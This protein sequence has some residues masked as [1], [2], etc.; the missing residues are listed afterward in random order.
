[1][2]ITWIGGGERVMDVIAKQFS[3]KIYTLAKMGRGERFKNIEEISNIEEKNA[4]LR[5]QCY[6][7]W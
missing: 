6:W 3:G 2:W 7:C 4:A 5:L 1:M